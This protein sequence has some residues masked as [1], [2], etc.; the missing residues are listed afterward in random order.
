[1]QRNIL[2]FFLV[3]SSLKLI[4][5]PVPAV[6][7][8]IPHLVTFGKEGDKA[9]GDN[10][11]TQIIFYSVPKD[12]TEP[13]YIR[14][15]DPDVGGT[16]DEQKGEWDSRMK[17]SIYGGEGAC[18][19][20]DAKKINLSGNFKSGTLL[21]TKSFTENERYD[22]KWY[23]FGPFNPTEG[24]YLPDYGGYI[25]KVVIEGVDGDDGNLYRLFMSQ[26][27]TEN[28]QVEGA[29]AFYFRYKFRLH[30]DVNEI[31]HIYPFIDEN[32]LAIKQT[33]FDWDN[34]GF[35]RI[36]SVA[37]NGEFLKVSGDNDWSESLH[38]VHPNEKNTSYDIQLIKKK[39]AK[40]KSNNVVIFLKNQY[41]ELM[42]FYSVPIGGIPKYKYSIGI[43]P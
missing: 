15:F 37:K 19:N 35:I 9:W 20:D 18:S 26:L 25:I 7:E 6:D 29:F 27:P 23:T 31:S 39:T 40:I 38:E 33:N 21:G 16:V 30:D 13:I 8:N 43:K 4:A 22:G 42:P 34:D 11:F 24:E 32:V 10:D 14:V 28:Q 12:H 5:Q 1:M 17:Y 41:D 36:I 3:L 2:L